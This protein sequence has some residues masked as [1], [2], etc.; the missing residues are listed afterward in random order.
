[1]F[2][3]RKYK[4]FRIWKYIIWNYKKI[5]FFSFFI[6]FYLLL[7]IFVCLFNFKPKVLRIFYSLMNII[8]VT[9]FF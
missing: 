2:Q 8:F 3:K 4:K 6:L 5:L 1:M 7:F 9:L